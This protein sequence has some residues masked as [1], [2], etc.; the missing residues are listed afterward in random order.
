MTA[1]TMSFMGLFMVGARDK[2]HPDSGSRRR[3]FAS[4][5]HPRK[6]D[7]FDPVAASSIRAG[8][9]RTMPRMVTTKAL[10]MPGCSAG[11]GM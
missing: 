4:R 3:V 6:V 2:R 7:V 9:N 11:S 10:G 5:V 1:T 8:Q